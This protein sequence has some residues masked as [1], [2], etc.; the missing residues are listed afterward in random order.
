MTSPFFLPGLPARSFFAPWRTRQ[1]RD[2]GLDRQ[3]TVGPAQK[4]DAVRFLLE[5]QQK[6]MRQSCEMVGLSR[7]AWDRPPLDWTVGD[8]EII[9]ALAELIKDQPARGF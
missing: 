9:G 4:Q 6:P 2:E 5:E 1:R 3:K 7:A 8:A